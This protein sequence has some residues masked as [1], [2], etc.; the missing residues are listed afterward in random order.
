[1]SLTRRGLL[2]AGL[3]L[4]GAAVVGS[5]AG[6]LWRLARPKHSGLS[7]QTSGKA[8]EGGC[9]SLVERLD[10]FAQN[11]VSGGVPPDGIPPIENPRYLSADEAEAALTGGSIPRTS[12]KPR[13]IAEPTAALGGLLRDDS[14]V[15]GMDYRGVV[16]AFPQIILVWHEIV[17]EES[18]GEQISITYCPLT[19]SVVGYRGGS[20]NFGTSG[21]LLNSNLVMYDRPT[22]SYWPQ[23][24]GMAVKGEKKGE[25]L[26]SFPIIWT[27]WG[28]WKAVYPQT[29]VLTA[30]TG[31]VRAYGRDPYGSYQQEDTYYQSGGPFFPVMAR[32]GRFPP[33]KV[34]VGVRVKDCALAIPKEEF[35]AV[36]ALNTALATEPI[37]ALYDEPLDVVRVYSRRIEGE[38]DVLTFERTDGRF[39]DA[40]TG[41][42]WTAGGRALRG[43]LKDAR[44]KSVNHFDVMWFAWYAF[45]PNTRVL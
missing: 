13:P 45:Y 6:V 11:I 34:V 5:G 33:K 41:S 37:V 31:Y 38:G 18:S 30:E 10:K 43:P 29:L 26:G 32:N 14:I 8:T 9:P 36:K 28:R 42:E 20:F 16:K 44:L 24:L 25:E 12:G 7:V 3:L 4:G 21:R 1:M 2:K 23:I 17:N 22:K 35:R 15:F 19:G 27:T 40:E 39:L